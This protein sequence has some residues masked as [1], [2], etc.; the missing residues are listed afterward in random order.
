MD[1]SIIIVNYNT[2][3]MTQECID[4]I[5]LHTSG[6]DYE[7]ILVDNASTDG[8]SEYFSNADGITFVSSP[9]NLGF[10][11][12]NNLGAEKASG[13]YLF[14]LNSDTLLLNNAAKIFFDFMEHAPENI[15]CCGCILQ[16]RDGNEIHSYG[17]FHTLA[18]CLDEWVWQGI[19]KRNYVSTKYDNPKYRKGNSFQ[20]PFVT[21]ADLFVRKSVSD[22][23]GLFDPDFF[24]YSEDME[25]QFRYFKKGFYSHILNGPCIIHLSK[26]SNRLN[27]LP[28]VEML[29]YS[30][31]LYK[32][33][34]LNA[35]AYLLFSFVFKTIYCVTFLGSSNK[36][37]AK[38][39]HIRNVVM[40]K[41]K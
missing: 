2:C 26:K 39:R 15:A 16:D 36:W 4:N 37:L 1:V 21:G 41:I 30:M 13:K 12:A 14:L 6:I 18:N 28:R 3:Q 11:R 24:M 29:T 22:K 23:F 25:L 33:K 5:R 10:G 19:K 7:I 35:I 9:E 20:V 32:K 31:L 34:E 38:I 40:M 27:K 17:D 8:S